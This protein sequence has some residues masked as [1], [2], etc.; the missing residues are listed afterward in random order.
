MKVGI[1][2]GDMLKEVELGLHVKHRVELGQADSVYQER[3][4]LRT[5]AAT[6]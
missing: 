5:D 4:I 1:V 6:W 3:H 2:T